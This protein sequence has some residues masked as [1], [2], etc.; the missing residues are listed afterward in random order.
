[1]IKQGKDEVGIVVDAKGKFM[2][3]HS[4]KNE[5]SEK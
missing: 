3:K 2:G 4:E 1:V 5:K